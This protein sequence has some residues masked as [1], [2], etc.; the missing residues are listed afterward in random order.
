MAH[1]SNRPRTR[2]NFVSDKFSLVKFFFLN[3]MF[4]FSLK[5]IFFPPLQFLFLVKDSS[6]NFE[7]KNFCEDNLEY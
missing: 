5:N 4:Q 2:D 1:I 7:F 3:K 6:F